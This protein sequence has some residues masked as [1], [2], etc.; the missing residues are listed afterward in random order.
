MFG[1]A[2]LLEAAGTHAIAQDTEIW[3]WEIAI[4]PADARLNI[5]GE[6]IPDGF[7][8]PGCPPLP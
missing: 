3:G 6:N 7:C 5:P 4:A 1:A 2:K 8:P